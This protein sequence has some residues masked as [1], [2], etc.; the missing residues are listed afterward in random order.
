[1]LAPDFRLPRHDARGNVA[2]L[3]QKAAVAPVHAEVGS[4]RYSRQRRV[5]LNLKIKRPEEAV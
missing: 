1:M 5:H 4:R 3:D 2:R